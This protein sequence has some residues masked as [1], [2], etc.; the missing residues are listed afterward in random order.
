[1]LTSKKFHKVYRI[2]RDLD[3]TEFNVLIT[4]LELKLGFINNKEYAN[5]MSKICGQIFDKLLKG[6]KYDKE[7]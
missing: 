5:K 2:V 1:M 7:N 3:V 4:T 6:A